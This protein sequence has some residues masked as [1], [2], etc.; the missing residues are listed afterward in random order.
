MNTES[1]EHWR[2]EE[3]EIKLQKLAESGRRVFD[4]P[5]KL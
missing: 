2:Q 5:R 1:L 3:I 4:C